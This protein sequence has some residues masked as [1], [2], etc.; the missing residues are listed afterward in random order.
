MNTDED[1][2]GNRNSSTLLVRMNII[3]ST[4]GI[5]MEV[6]HKSKNR[7]NIWPSYTNSPLYTEKIQATYTK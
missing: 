2:V 6:T 5:R 3:K 7:N 1:D 4:I